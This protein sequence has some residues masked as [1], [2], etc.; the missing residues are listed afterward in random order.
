MDLQTAVD[1]ARARRRAVLVTTRDDGRPQ[2]SN[3]LHGI[4]ESGLIRVSVTATRAKYKNLRK[5][6][7][8]ALHVASED[9]WS[10]VVVEGDVELSPV[11]TDPDGP[12]ADEHVE[13]YRA[14]AGEHEDWADYRASLVREQ[15]AFVRLTP[16]YAY[17][18]AQPG[19]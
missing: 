4:D 6:P 12:D 2:L 16:T 7:W 19:S 8:A 1:F 11:V 18:L 13:H 14:L 17:G 9:F 5:R 15:R 3:V 10:Y